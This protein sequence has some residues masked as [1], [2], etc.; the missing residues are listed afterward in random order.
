MFKFALNPR[1]S[2]VAGEE[3]R[4]KIL[5]SLKEMIVSEAVYPCISAIS[6][7]LNVVKHNLR[8]WKMPS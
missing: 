3:S 8:M 6:P 1:W 7:R 2:A 4:E 5:E